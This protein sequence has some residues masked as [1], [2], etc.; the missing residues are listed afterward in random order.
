MD[1]NRNRLKLPRILLE[2][3]V[4]RGNRKFSVHLRW[5]VM[6]KLS[7]LVATMLLAGLALAQPPLRLKALK[8]DAVRRSRTFNAPLKTRTHGRSHVLIQFADGP[9]GDQLNEL[10][11]RGVAVL[12]Y[13]PDLALSVS[14][15]DDTSFD[16]LNIQWVGR[17]RPDEKIS[18]ELDTLQ[19]A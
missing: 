2:G 15:R 9:N 19:A 12:S 10:A 11:N 16:G 18:P 3:V 6:R 17:L 13:V 4:C 5:K 1:R 7:Y 14:A 8:R